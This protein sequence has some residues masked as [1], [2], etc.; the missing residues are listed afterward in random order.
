[1]SKKSAFLFFLILLLNS[2]LPAAEKK[3]TV[4]TTLFPLY[5]FARNIGQDKV[6]VTLL[7]PPGIEAHSYE[8]SA[9]DVLKV[10]GAEIFIYT[11]KLMEPWAE[12]FVRGV[13]SN[14]LLVVEAGEYFT[15]KDPHTWLDFSKA[16]A[17]VNRIR[18]AFIAKDVANKF[19]YLATAKQ[20]NKMLTDLDAEYQKTLVGCQ[21]KV[22]IHG[23]HFAFGYLAQRYRLRY[24]AAYKGF[25]PEAEPTPRNL[26]ELVDT[27]KQYKVKYIF[28]EELISPRVAE[29]LAQETGAQL[30]KLSAA[31]NLTRKEL[32]RGVSFIEIM[33]ANLEN[34]K[35]GLLCQ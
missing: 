24:I 6:A 29:V 18:D 7:L 16:L 10:S 13:D 15:A 26:A 22:L 2:T 12:K 19:F 28:Y 9:G 17:M 25:S 14:K 27:I 32:D 11:S 34:L 1:M 23:G 21:N 31:H 20:Y 30:L 4:V 5:D 3:L 8:P 33:K 35:K